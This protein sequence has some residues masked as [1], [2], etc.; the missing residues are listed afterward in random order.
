MHVELVEPSGELTQEI[1]V[2]NVAEQ[3]VGILIDYQA[4]EVL[5]RADFV[6]AEIGIDADTAL[7]ELEI[8]T[9]RLEF[10][11]RTHRE[12]LITDETRGAFVEQVEDQGVVMPRF[13]Q[14]EVAI[15]VVIV[16]DTDR[17]NRLFG[18]N[19]IDVSLEEQAHLVLFRVVEQLVAVATVIHLVEVLPVLSLQRSTLV[20]RGRTTLEPVVATGSLLLLVQDESGHLLVFGMGVSFEHFSD[21]FAFEILEGKAII[22]GHIVIIGEDG[23]ADLVVRDKRRVFVH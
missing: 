23:H 7:A 14:F 10:E 5:Q 13:H 20:A 11:N 4:E 17:G 6:F 9:E 1:P 18:T 3:I 12:T 2:G 22:A 21:T 8:G 19:V 16:V 15:V